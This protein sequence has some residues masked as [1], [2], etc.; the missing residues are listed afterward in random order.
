MVG[1]DGGTIKLVSSDAATSILEFNAEPVAYGQDLGFLPVTSSEISDAY[2]MDDRSA[3]SM[4]NTADEKLLTDDLC[5][6]SRLQSE[7]LILGLHNQEYI[8]NLKELQNYF[9]MVQLLSCLWTHNAEYLLLLLLSGL[10]YDQPDVRRD[11][12]YA[13]Q[14]SSMTTLAILE[15]K[16]CQ[17]WPFPSAKDLLVL[18][19][20]GALK[21]Y[22]FYFLCTGYAY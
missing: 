4:P 5:Q 2:Q 17:Q 22:G 6:N 9:D 16:F 18:E 11:A 21:N 8:G 20:Q 14:S 3:I 7:E 1:P 19:I 15:H 10:S 12:L 13:S